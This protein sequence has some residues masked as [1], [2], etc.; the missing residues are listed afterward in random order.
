VLW[1][2]FVFN[3][4]VLL[5]LCFELV[6]VLLREAWTLAIEALSW[7]EMRGLS[8][9]L[10]LAKTVR[11]LNIQDRDAIRLARLL[12]VETVRRR[13]FIDAFVNNAIKPAELSQFNLGIQSF[14]R[15][16]VYHV[17]LARN[18]SAVDLGEAENIV[19]LARSILGWQTLQPIEPFLGVL[20][21]Q[22]PAVVLERASDVACVGLGTFHSPW[23]VEYCFKLFGRKEAIALL[24]SDVSS[25]PLCVRLNTL[26]A[27][28]D[29]ILR[30]LKEEGIEVE[31]IEQTMSAFKII[32]TTKP[33]T[34]T[35]CFQ[36][37][38]IRVEDK[39]DSFVA[40]AANPTPGMTVLDVCCAPGKITTHLGELMENDGLLVS[41]D[42][43]MRRMAAWNKEVQNAGVR[44]AEPMIADA[45][46][47]LPVTVKADLVVL[48]P[49]CTG[50]GM[51][52][53][54]PSFKWRLTPRSIDRMAD[55]QWQMLDN[56]AEYVRSGGALTYST[57]SITVEENEMLI[58]KFLKRHLEFSLVDISP[59]MGSLGLRGLVNCRRLYPHVHNCNGL[60]VAKLVKSKE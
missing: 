21:S 42:Y 58:E 53:R 12:M 24:E 39:A 49:P 19:K 14:L 18:W 33:I 56:C 54:L 27:E 10:A 7:M 60:F 17:R 16:Y 37:G 47:T 23:F 25:P 15:L 52:S 29:E 45:S 44:I 40:E 4:Y 20:L 41:I 57:S 9:P 2:C 32:K 26:I 59:E 55:I 5:H 48:D 28:P 30:R 51:F 1:S 8:E 46:K 6:S 13:N 22:K 50:T 11:Q 38:L 43:S 34:Q 35:D 31:K 3:S 36:K